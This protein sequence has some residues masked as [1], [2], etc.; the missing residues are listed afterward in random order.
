MLDASYQQGIAIGGLPGQASLAGNGGNGLVVITPVIS[1]AAFTIPIFYSGS[2]YTY[3]VPT[4]VTYLIVKVGNAAHVHQEIMTH[5]LTTF[6][7]SH[8]ERTL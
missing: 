2:D 7:N 3:T 8:P 4:G 5:T 6:A 1:A